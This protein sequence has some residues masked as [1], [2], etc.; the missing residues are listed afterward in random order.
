MRCE[1]FAVS[2]PASHCSRNEDSFLVDS[3]VGAFVVA[4]GVGGMPGGETASCVAASAFV[5]ELR[6]LEPA[7]RVGEGALRGAVDAANAAVRSISAA[8][9][10]L[11][12]LATT[13]SAAVF[14]GARGKLVHV[15]DSRIYRVTPSR[16]EQLTRDHTLVA[17]LVSKGEL[18]PA[19]VASHP[20][21]HVLTR[22]VGARPAVDPQLDDVTLAPKEALILATD[23]LAKALSPELIHE[24]MRKAAPGESETVCRALV[25][26][27]VARHPGDDV[28]A[29]VLCLG[30]RDQYERLSDNRRIES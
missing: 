17:E 24:L 30:E 29:L 18:D 14:Q 3:D 25:R 23:G 16:L 26:E 2:E 19:D 27:A 28:T 21:R 9:P 8:D 10:T 22:A 11:Q 13:L 7:E 20:L 4:D 12:G 1:A 15:G 5:D 6:R